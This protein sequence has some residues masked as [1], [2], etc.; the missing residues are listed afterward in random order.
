M[1]NVTQRS[2]ILTYFRSKIPTQ[3]GSIPTQT[4]SAK[5]VDDEFHRAILLRI[6]F[7]KHGNVVIKREDLKGLVVAP[8]VGGNLFGK[9]KGEELLLALPSEALTKMTVHTLCSL[10]RIARKEGV[11]GYLQAKIQRLLGQDKNGSEKSSLDKILE[12]SPNIN[13]KCE[14]SRIVFF[15]RLSV[16]HRMET[17]YMSEDTT[18][19]IVFDAATAKTVRSSLD[20]LNQACGE[21]AKERTTNKRQ[22]EESTE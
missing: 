1:I 21:D 6:Y 12:H 5:A 11:F 13:K 7:E 2:I 19:F 17:E 4:G 18:R 10:I 14:V 9:I 22:R 8:S 3:T 16:F 15:A 20:S